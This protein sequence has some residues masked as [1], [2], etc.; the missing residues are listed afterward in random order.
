[1]INPLL[2]LKG[3]GQS[4]WYDNIERDLIL[5]GGLMK[6]ITEDGVGGITSNPTIFHKAISES[7]EYDHAISDLVEMGISTAEIL[8]TLVIQD[9]S[10]AADLLRP[11][12]NSTDTVDGWVS[13]EVPASLANDVTAT[14]AEVERLR[15][16]VDRPNALVK[17]PAT[18][19]GVRAIR[20]SISR[21]WSINVTLIFSLDRYR[22]VMEAYLSGLETLV[23]RRAAGEDLPAPATVRS[24]AS[25]FVSRVDTKID[26]RLEEMARTATADGERE[27]LLALRGKAA[28][29]NARLAYQE[30]L[31]VFQGPRWEALASAGAKVQRPLWASTSTKSPEYSDIIYVENLI[32]PNTV[33][34]MPQVS[35]DAYRDHGQVDCGSLNREVEESRRLLGELEAHGVSMAQVTAELEVEGVKAFADSHDKLFAALDEKRQRIAAQVGS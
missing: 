14:L 3:C 6:M 31:R 32:G 26:K 18:A 12:F 16:A 27:R 24:V 19:E 8:D 13:I 30:F 11:T 1:M 9:I 28:V 4:V 7:S 25:F 35:I 17:I 10:M 29:A 33:N 15:K 34:T 20:E 2:G 5:T 22:E 23:A 21:G